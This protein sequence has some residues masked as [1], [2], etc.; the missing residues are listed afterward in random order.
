MLLIEEF[1]LQNEGQ[2]S[3]FQWIDGLGMCNP[4]ILLFL[5]DRNESFPYRSFQRWVP[6]PPNPP[7]MTN[8]EKEEATTHRGRNYPVGLH[9]ILA[10]SYSFISN[11]T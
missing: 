5:Y 8:E 7:S 1:I 9:T 2:C 3:F 11:S 10:L 4:Q 6:P